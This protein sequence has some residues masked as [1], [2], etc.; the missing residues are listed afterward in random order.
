VPRLRMH[1]TV[2][3][4]PHTWRGAWLRTGS[5]LPHHSTYE[6]TTHLH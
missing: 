1:E 6:N 2:T 4:L 3:P 5:N